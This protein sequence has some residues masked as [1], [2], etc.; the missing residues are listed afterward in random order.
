MKQQRRC[1]ECIAVNQD[2]TLKVESEL[3][4]L[5]NDAPPLPSHA[6][7]EFFKL[8]PPNEEC[9]ICFHPLQLDKQQQTYE[10]CCGK[11]VCIGCIHAV[12]AGDDR[13]LCPFCRA[14]ATVS[15]G[16]RMERLKKRAD[17]NDAEAIYN[18]GC[19]YDR[20]IMGF[21]RD[22]KKANKLWLRAGE[23]GHASAYFN[24]AV[25]Y[26]DGDGVENNMN[27]AKYY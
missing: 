11:I 12:E 21:R 10:A 24:L 17:A 23:L 15:D 16:E 1:K 6:D 2:V 26:R 14:P 8:P 13:I 4:A 22:W 19:A 18:L 5:P 3:E 7:E 20:G 27:K 25:A 9:P